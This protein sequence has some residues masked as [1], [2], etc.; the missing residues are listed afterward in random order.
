VTKYL[1]RQGSPTL[2]YARPQVSQ[3]TTLGFAGMKP[4][5]A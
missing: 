3:Y 2:P 1:V 5:L 4:G